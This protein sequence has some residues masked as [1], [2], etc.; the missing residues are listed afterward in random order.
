VCRRQRVL[1]EWFKTNAPKSMKE[2]PTR[3]DEVLSLVQ[4]SLKTNTGTKKKKVT[5]KLPRR[6]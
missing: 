6:V 5:E 4:L 1:T 3:Y 2:E